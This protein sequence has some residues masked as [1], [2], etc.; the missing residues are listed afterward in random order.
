MSS[1]RLKIGLYASVLLAVFV[2]ASYKLAQRNDARSPQKDEVLIK[3][4]LQ[5][6]SAA[7]YQPERIDD[8]FSKRVFD[9]YL[10]RIDASKKFLLQSDVA[11]LRKYQNDI[12]NQVQRGT[13]EFLDLSTQLMNQRVKD[14]QGLYREILAKPFDFTVEETFERPRLPPTKPPSGK[15]GASF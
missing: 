1:P 13:H 11:Q 4:M 5:A 3:A 15:S 12:D 10:K 6:L 8:A 9:L 14:I 7:H 2:L